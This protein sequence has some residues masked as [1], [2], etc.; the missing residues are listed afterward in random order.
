MEIDSRFF[1]IFANIINVHLSLM[2]LYITKVKPRTRNCRSKN[3]L[4]YAKLLLL[5]VDTV[6]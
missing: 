5:N 4:L 2:S 3:I 6:Y 1:N